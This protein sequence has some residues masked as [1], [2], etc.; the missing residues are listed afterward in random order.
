[1]TFDFKKLKQDVKTNSQ[2]RFSDICVIVIGTKG[3]SSML[4]CLLDT[5]CTKSIV[6]MKFTDKKQRS[7]L[8][9]KDT[10]C[11]TTYDKRLQMSIACALDIFHSI[12]MDLLGDFEHVLVYIDDILIIQKVGESEAGHM[13][14][15]EQVLKHLDAKGFCANLRKSFFM[16]KEV[17][18][19]TYLL[20]TGG[21][22]SQ[23]TKLKAMHCIMRLKNSKQLRM[24]L[25]MD[26][27]LSRYVP[28]TFSFSCA[29]QQVGVD[30]GQG[31][32]L[33]HN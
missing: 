10:V 28:K 7:K 8:S 16:Q 31:L 18:Y 6:L 22:K 17:E 19:L 11:Y 32:V 20:T 15:I 30:E 5:G 21:L 2:Q 13:K 27:F 12:M 9:K 14:K 25:G 3:K 24:F 1:M 23:P 33:G 26:E 4:C 29:T